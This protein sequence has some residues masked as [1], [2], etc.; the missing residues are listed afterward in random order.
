MNSA[1]GRDD[2]PAMVANSSLGKRLAAALKPDLSILLYAGPPF[3]FGWQGLSVTAPIVWWVILAALALFSEYRPDPGYDELKSR[4]VAFGIALVVFVA[5][6]YVA[7]W[8][9]PN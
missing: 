2:Q 1:A 7:R 6:Y 4:P 8:L 5:I 9:S 3:F